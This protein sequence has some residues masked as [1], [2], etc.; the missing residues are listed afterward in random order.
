MK[1]DVK[2]FEVKGERKKKL[3]K[4]VKHYMEDFSVC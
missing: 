4:N 1:K 3:L 2:S